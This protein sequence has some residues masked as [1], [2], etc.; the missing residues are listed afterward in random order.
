VRA[1]ELVRVGGRVAVISYHSLE[2]RIAKQTFRTAAE[3]CT[4]PKDLPV[5]VCGKTPMVKVLTN[6]P[7]RPDD[8]E[9]ARN[10]RSD[11]ARMRVAE[12]IREAA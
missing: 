9:V 3:G 5:C 4:C 11:S 10:P 12:K 6:R 7:V 2:D 8:Q 1:L